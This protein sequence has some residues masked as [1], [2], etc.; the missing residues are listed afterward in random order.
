MTVVEFAERALELVVSYTESL[1]DAVPGA[2]SLSSSADI[3][4]SRG[5]PTTATVQRGVLAAL[6]ALADPD[7]TQAK[8]TE[9]L[10]RIVDAVRNEMDLENRLDHKRGWQLISLVAAAVR[11]LVADNLITHPHGFKA[12]NNEDFGAWIIR[13]GAGSDVLESPLVRGL[14]D[15]VFGYEDADSERPA[16]AAGVMV[17]LIGF[18]LFGYKGA[19]FWKMTA[20]MGD[21][22]MAPLYE[23]LR[24]R[25]VHFEFFHRVDALHLD[26][27]RQT[28]EAVTVGRQA[29][30]ADGV[31]EYHPLTAV[32]GLPVF[33]NAPLTSQIQ[34]GDGQDDL[35][36]HF[37]RRGDAE[38]RVLRRGKDFDHVVLAMSLGMIP[39]VATELIDDRPEWRDMTTHVR[40]IATQ[41]FQLWLRPDEPA[42]GWS[43]PGA[44][45]SAYVRPFETWA[46]MPQTLW[47]E[48]WP[49]GDRPGTV[50]YFCGSLNAPWPTTEDG[51]A[52]SRRFR[53]LAHAEAADYTDRYLGLFF[54]NALDQNGFD[55]ALLSGV[56]GERGLAALETQHVSVN[57][58]PSDRYVQSVPG[59]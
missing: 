31:D 3:S 47:A 24:K 57:I 27:R 48:D 34:G 30:L 32:Q 50:A 53:D 33:P 42:L 17:F 2:L 21:I 29:R 56:N 25:G 7:V 51:S 10:D 6:L 36:S 59:S 28:V 18:V 38:T 13:H 45:I 46:S 49:D 4:P 40:T 11:G 1:R 16:V 14:Y 55:W 9:T 26:R 41:A 15:L 12:I 44:T 20:G 39:V 37:G 5:S 58:D 43:K 8:L 54:P 23:A 19:I 52:Y 35:E 22:V